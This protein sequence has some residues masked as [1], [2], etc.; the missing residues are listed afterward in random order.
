MADANLYYRHS[1]RFSPLALLPVMAVSILIAAAAG[2]A[3][4]IIVYYMPLIYI[5]ALLCIGLGYS[6]GVLV[7]KM[8]MRQHIR[9]I[10]VIA[11]TGL[12]AG[13]AAEYAAFVGWLLPVVGWSA[14]I[15]Q[16]GE[17]ID[18]LQ[19]VADKGVWGYSSGSPITGIFLYLHWL[20]EGLVLIGAAAS[21]SISGL[22]ET[23]YCETCGQW[24][25]EASVVGPFQPI[26]EVKTLR[27]NLERGDF[28]AL[29]DVKPMDPQSPASR[30]S[31]IELRDCPT[32]DAMAVMTVRN[33]TVSVDG[34][35]KATT[36]TEPVVSGLLIDRA[37][38][39]LVRQV[40]PQPGAVAVDA[41][42]KAQDPPAEA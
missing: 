7:R 29:G 9:N 21:N 19:V 20:A 35:G 6:L 22:K 26:A 11:L 12:L 25:R 23:P 13:L 15:Y 14:V 41:A 28:A 4:G 40:M 10:Q 30:F 17:L 3:Y 24:L 27:D 5:N 38:S 39:E 42:P 34:E 33:I 32:C 2:V 31:Q 36:T 37:T 1:G 8:A 18:V 16:P